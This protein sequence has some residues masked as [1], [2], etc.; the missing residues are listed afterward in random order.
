MSHCGNMSNRMI[1]LSFG[2]D[3]T[4]RGKTAAPRFEIEKRSRWCALRFASGLSFGQSYPTKT[5]RVFF[6]AFRSPERGTHMKMKN[7][8]RQNCRAPIFKLRL[9]FVCR[10]SDR[11]IG[12]L[13]Y[14]RTTFLSIT[15][16]QSFS[17]AEHYRN[18]ILC[19]IMIR[20]SPNAL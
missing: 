10:S 7:E 3:E 18:F 19:Q 6:G 13:C 17:P 4:G 1:L 20:A 11:G 9:A 8:T 5:R 16:F 12:D 15:A 14:F 2:C